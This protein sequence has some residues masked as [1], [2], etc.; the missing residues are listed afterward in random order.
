MHEAGI[1]VYLYSTLHEAEQAKITGSCIW[2]SPSFAGEAFNKDE[3]NNSNFLNLKWKM[4]KKLWEIVENCV[5]S[6]KQK[7]ILFLKRFFCKVRWEMK[8]K[9]LFKLFLCKQWRD[10]NILPPINYPPLFLTTTEVAQT[11]TGF[12]EN[13]SLFYT[14]NDKTN[15]LREKVFATR[16]VKHERGCKHPCVGWLSLWIS[17]DISRLL[18]EAVDF[19]LKLWRNLKICLMIKWKKSE[20]LQH[21]SSID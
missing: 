19:L 11:T 13:C 17:L 7:I 6:K 5:I 8:I 2:L 21:V 18:N 9:N 12:P 10:S 1:L 14:L 4:Y 15:E 20:C 16:K 3:F